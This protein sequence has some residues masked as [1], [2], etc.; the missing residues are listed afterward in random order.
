MPAKPIYL[1]GF[2]GSGKTTTGRLLAHSLRYDFTD[3][4][5]FIEKQEKASISELFERH[6]ESGF[7]ELER[8][9]LHETSKLKDVVIATG[10][11]VPCFFDNMDVMNKM[12]TTIYLK[13]SPE[14]LAYRLL[15][16]QEH[17]PL[18]AGKTREEL[19][20]FI[21]SKLSEREPWYQKA[22]IIAD[23]ASLPPKEIVEL[24]IRAIN[25]PRK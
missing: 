10:G 20:L 24:I 18:I 23:T 13:L 5:E 15:R 3:L 8:Y 21:R 12:G 11:G 4:D 1:T 17:R 9:A 2:M 7:R 22:Q 19:Q 16:G 14:N 25:L 6:G